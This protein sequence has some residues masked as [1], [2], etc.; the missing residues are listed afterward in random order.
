MSWP[1]LLFWPTTDAVAVGRIVGAT[2]E[3]RRIG[4]AGRTKAARRPTD[5]K[6]RPSTMSIGGRAG[7]VAAN[8]EAS[9]VMG[10]G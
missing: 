6:E 3:R 10:N 8:G 1:L 2:E 9:R 5:P 4:A 7:G